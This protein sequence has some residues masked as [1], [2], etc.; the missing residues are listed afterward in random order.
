M[1]IINREEI[2]ILKY[3]VQG[4]LTSVYTK[5]KGKKVKLTL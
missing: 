5:H 2:Y 3:K 1:K 4:F